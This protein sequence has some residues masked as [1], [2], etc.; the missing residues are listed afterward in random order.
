[1]KHEPFGA[2]IQTAFTKNLELGSPSTRA[3][4]QGINNNTSCSF[5]LTPYCY[6]L[7]PAIFD[8]SD[9]TLKV[10]LSEPQNQKTVLN[11]LAMPDQLRGMTHRGRQRNFFK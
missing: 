5:K 4:H 1:M 3:L 11:I 8:N 9:S 10:F 2:Q 7:T 6:V